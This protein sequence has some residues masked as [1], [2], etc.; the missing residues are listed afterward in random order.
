MSDGPAVPEARRRATVVI[1]N[2]ISPLRR[3]IGLVL[4]FIGMTWLFIGL[5]MLGDSFLSGQTWFAVVGGAIAIVGLWIV[6]RKP[7]P[8]S[9]GDSTG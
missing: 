5:G 3:A 2:Q 1:V 7:K 9:G 8:T 6:T 4:M